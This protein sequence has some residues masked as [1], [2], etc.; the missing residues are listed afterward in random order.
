MLLDS[1][2]ERA[3]LF[4]A[5]LREKTSEAGGFAYRGELVLKEG[6]VADAQGRRKPPLILLKEAAVLEAGGKLTFITGFLDEVGDLPLLIAMYGADFSPELKAAIFVA[7]IPSAIVTEVGGVEFLLIPLTQGFIW[8]ELVDEL[9]MEKGDFK[10]L[11]A[12]D[13]VVL[14]AAELRKY[15]PKYRK[16]PFDEAQVNITGGKREMHGAV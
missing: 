4:N 12:G 14:L 6:E 2:Q 9:G 8:N 1:Y 5:N 16:V 7:N 11:S 13:K 3:L 15:K 10:G